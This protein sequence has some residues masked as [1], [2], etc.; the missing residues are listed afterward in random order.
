MRSGSVHCSH[1]HW[2]RRTYPNV[3][4]SRT[5]SPPRYVGRATLAHATRHLP[6]DAESEP[7]Q[8]KPQQSLS[9]ARRIHGDT[10]TAIKMCTRIAGK[11]TLA[12]VARPARDMS[13]DFQVGNLS[14]AS[15][16]ISCK[17]AFFS[18]WTDSG[19][20]QYLKRKCTRGMETTDSR[21][22]SDQHY[23]VSV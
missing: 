19:T 11:A 9:M 13:L 10:L 16:T 23:T 15:S 3:V 22:Q 14:A 18:W 12:S 5:L 1:S 20:P 7:V 8:M 17:S 2:R 6:P 4:R 21:Q